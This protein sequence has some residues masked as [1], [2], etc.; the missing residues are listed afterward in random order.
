MATSEESAWREV[1]KGNFSKILS[2][3]ET[4]SS[5]MWPVEIAEKGEKK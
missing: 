5:N 2:V 4:L 3:E 1:S